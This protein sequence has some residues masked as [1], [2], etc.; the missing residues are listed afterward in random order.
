MVR[1]YALI[2]IF[3][4]SCNLLDPPTHVTEDLQPFVD[5]VVYEYEIRGVRVKPIK[6]V[7]GNLNVAGR[8]ISKPWD[9]KILID[10]NNFY[11]NLE[12]LPFLNLG[13][14]SHEIGHYQGRD[15]DNKMMDNVN[16]K[17]LMCEC[18]PWNL[19]SMQEYYFDEL[20]GVKLNP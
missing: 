9:R 5:R 13:I 19:E 10:E 17:S 8:Y 1:T 14:I 3:L 16:P 12:I 2:L 6:V 7:F 4:S 15:H 11:A 20:V 18:T